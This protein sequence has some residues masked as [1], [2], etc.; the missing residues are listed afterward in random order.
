MELGPATPRPE[1]SPEKKSEQ[2]TLRADVE[3]SQVLVSVAGE[4][5]VATAE[6]LRTFASDVVTPGIT[7][8]V[9]DLTEVTFLDSRGVQALLVAPR[10]ATRLGVAF[11]LLCSEI[12][13]PVAMVLDTLQVGSVLTVVR[14]SSGPQG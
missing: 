4:I 9:I 6:A 11:S 2:M 3:G 5:D 14:T 10:E 1:D 7:E 12:N 13:G 8:Q